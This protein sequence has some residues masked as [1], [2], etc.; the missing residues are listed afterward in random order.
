MNKLLEFLRPIDTLIWNYFVKSKF[1]LFCGGG[2]SAD[3][4]YVEPRDMGEDARSYLETITDPELVGKQLNAEKEFGPQ[5]DLVSLSRTQIMLEGIKD[6]KESQ[7]Y[8]SATARRI[9]LQAKKKALLEGKERLSEEDIQKQIDILLPEPE[10][11][12]RKSKD[13]RRAK[14]KYDS[15]RAALLKN[16]T[17]SNDVNETVSEIDAE[18]A[19]VIETITQIE[20]Q[21]AQKGLIEMAEDTAKAYDKIIADSNTFKRERD[22]LDMDY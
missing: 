9:A 5:F 14:E 13:R 3:P 20:N 22:I 2:K 21:P 15:D 8:G 6:P 1:I 17:E 16:Y 7:A 19:G 11:N 4:V 12:Q 18:L 10:Y